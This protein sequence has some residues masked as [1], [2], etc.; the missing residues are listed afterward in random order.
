Y[1]TPPMAGVAR[2]E[3]I[4]VKYVAQEIAKIKKLSYEEVTIQT[5]KNAQVLFN[6]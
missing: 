1:L 6:I 3:P 4:F 2:N 5:T